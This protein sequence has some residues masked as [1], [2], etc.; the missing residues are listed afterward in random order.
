MTYTLHVIAREVPANDADVFTFLEQVAGHTVSMAPSQQL[1]NFRDAALKLF[2]CLSSYAATD[3]AIDDCPWADG[4]LGE[5]FKGGYGTIGIARRHGEV[6]PHLIRIA[7][8]LGVTVA[9][10][11]SGAVHRPLTYQVV[12]ERA[13]PGVEME[14]A[15]AQ[16]AE[17]MNQP[18]D[19]MVTLLKSGRR[20]LVKRGL[21]R[22]QADIY[23]VAL[24]DRASCVASIVADPR[25][26]APAPAP[27]AA[28]TAAHKAV[29]K[30]PQAQVAQAPVP[31]VE[32]PEYAGIEADDNLFMAAEAQRMAAMTVAGSLILGVLFALRIKSPF[33]MP[34]LLAMSVL[35]V[36]AV[37]QFGKALESTRFRM[38]CFALLALLPG[39]GTLLLGWTYF[40]AAGILNNS[41]ITSGN[42]LA[43]ASV[44]RELGGMPEGAM[45]PS[46]KVLL[47]LL[48][49]A[50]IGG[51]MFAPV[52]H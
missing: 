21:T 24:R 19:Q 51:A 10:E 39:I 15:A 44:V 29:R 7:S 9:D 25:K 30:A 42:G 26:P 48:V 50:A 46:V 5:N 32:Q 23:V 6:I 17:L 3:A 13:V 41:D 4:P 14:V 40:R 11:Q 12:L 31:D 27:V 49:L 37:V 45:L 16:L 8:D 20:T 33:I 35:G 28:R 22:A 1:K 38:L 2:P 36:M 47:A 34:G 52:G 43:G 18:L